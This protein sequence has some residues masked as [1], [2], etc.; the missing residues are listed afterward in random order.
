MRIKLRKRIL[1]FINLTVVV[2]LI[3]SLSGCIVNDPEILEFAEQ[4]TENYL[5]AINNLD[6]DTYRKDFDD[7]MLSSIPE[8]EFIRFSTYLKDTIGDYTPGSKQFSYSSNQKGLYL[9]FY[10]ADYSFE[11]DVTIQ[12]IFVEEGDYYK[13]GGSWFD[14]E[15]I[16][17]ND[18]E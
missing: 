14:S 6:Y 17:E 8:E 12:M 11:K 16:Q 18:Y 2:L 1:F 15:K 9:I 3:L 13:I 10:T 4:S 5:I 7:I